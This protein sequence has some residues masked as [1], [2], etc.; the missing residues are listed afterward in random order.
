MKCITSKEFENENEIRFIGDNENEEELMKALKKALERKGVDP[1]NAVIS[2]KM[3]E[4]IA[5]AEIEENIYKINIA[6]LKICY[7]FIIEEEP[8]YYND[9]IGKK[10]SKLLNKYIHLPKNNQIIE[11]EKILAKIKKNNLFGLYNVNGGKEIINLINTLVF[12]KNKVANLETQHIIALIYTGQEVYGIV[13]LFSKV[14]GLYKLSNNSYDKLGIIIKIN[15]IIT[16]EVES[17]D[18]RIIKYN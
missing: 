9:K 8:D 18:L 6:L 5:E 1:S 14:W 12:Q 7:E 4:I 2:T 15:N 11:E 3:E 10:I 17:H 13:N 16:R